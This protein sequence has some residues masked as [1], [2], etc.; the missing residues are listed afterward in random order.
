LAAAPDPGEALRQYAPP[1]FVYGLVKR[2]LADLRSRRAQSGWTQ[3][4]EG[5]TLRKGDRG[6]R[7]AELRA[8]L[9]ERGDLPQGPKDDAAGAE[10]AN[11]QHDLGG[12]AAQPIYAHDRERR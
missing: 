9:M 4:T 1:S 8:I 5:P 7:V 3:A 10:I 12:V 2:A 6:P 11:G